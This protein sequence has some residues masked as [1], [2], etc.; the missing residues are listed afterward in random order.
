VS[1]HL[2]VLRHPSFRYLFLGQSASVI[3]DRVVV[4]ALALFV[5]QTTGSAGDLGLILASQALP[6]VALLLFG[7]VW[8]DRLPRHRIMV[9]ADLTRAALHTTLA[10]LIF[11]G[12]VEVWELAVIEAAFGAAQAFFQP[13]YTGLIPQTVPEEVIQ[14]ARALTQSVENVAFLV[15]PAIATGL[16]LGLGAGEAFALDAATF[17]LSAALLTRVRPRARGE[18]A[19]SSTLWAELRAGF[20]EVRSRA[21]VW[22][23]IAVFTGAMFTVY[24]PWYSLAPIVSRDA[25][26]S[27]AV[28]GVLESVGG[29]G[30]LLGA[31]AGMAWRPRRPLKTGMLLVLVWPLMGASLAARAPLAV[32]VVLSLATGFAFAQLMILWETALARYI[33]PRALSRVSSYDWMGSLALLPAG[34]LV[35]G[36][37]A[38]TFGA[39]AVLG[40]GSALGAVLLAA[41]LGLGLPVV[42][43]FVAT[44]LVPR[45][46]SAVLAASLVGL[47]FLAFTSG[48]I[49]DAVTRARAEAKRLAYLAI[50]A[51]RAEG[52][53]A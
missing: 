7:G 15:G 9:I 42:T 1:S 30:A 20:T 31:V 48:L 52:P 27:A 46:P 16:V 28:F 14:E 13:A 5:T 50:P 29:A 24:A 34:Y 40:F 33:P 23:T 35:V 2:R 43:E 26:G 37:L 45:L 49:L 41:G 10:A 39:R 38:S 22:V 44:G 32:V 17:V 11:A 51:P 47:S 4:V 12:A 6:L 53:E 8:A 36:P 3:G 21:W 25:Y 18:R 19:G